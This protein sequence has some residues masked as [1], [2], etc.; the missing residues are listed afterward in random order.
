MT[1]G[2]VTATCGSSNGNYILAG[3]RNGNV[4]MFDV[5]CDQ[6]S[7]KTNLKDA[8]LTLDW[9]EEKERPEFFFAGTASGDLAVWDIRMMTKRYQIYMGCPKRNMRLQSVISTIDN[10]LYVSSGQSIRQWSLGP[11]SG[12]SSPLKEWNIQSYAQNDSQDSDG[13]RSLNY[14][15]S[16]N[17]TGPILMASAWDET[18]SLAL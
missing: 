16:Q 3:C 8:V 13:I 12:P 17:P 2:A 6:T 15:D 11:S 18:Y 4:S 7:M 5:R 9:F 14:I 10:S 1:G